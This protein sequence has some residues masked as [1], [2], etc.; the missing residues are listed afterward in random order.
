[1]ALT[2]QQLITPVSESEAFDEAIAILQSLGFNATSW[3]SGS[4]PYTLVRLIA[5]LQASLS[6]TIAQIVEGAYLATASGAFL[7]LLGE[8]HYGRVRVEA[9]ATT[10]VFR[11][12]ASATAPPH[13]ISVGQLQIATTPTQESSTQTYRNT[14]GGTLNPG[15][16]LDLE[17]VAEVAGA[18]G[19]IPSSQALYLWT[20]LV[21]ATATNP[22][23]ATSGTWITEAGIDR[24]SDE[25]YRDRCSSRWSTLSYAAT[26]GAYR[27]WALEASSSVTRVKVRDDNP[28]GPGSI[29]V[30]VAS[31]V[32]SVSEA[33]RQTVEDYINGADG[34]GRRPLNDVLTVSKALVTTI[35]FIGTVTVESAKQSETNSGTI[36]AAVDAYLGELAI[37][38]VVIPPASSGVVPRS[39]LIALLQNM[40]GVLTVNLSTPAFDV[41]LGVSEVVVGSYANLSVVYV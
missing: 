20:P 5:R 6:L 1:M 7:D 36:A 26:E 23:D 28:Y 39:Q 25:R 34:V 31:S 37:G 9:T 35:G 11:L 13:T 16:T 33:V 29:E 27:N 10:G 14:T 30:I 18:A 38:G 19:N 8:S 12:T 32:G 2:V 17:V 22:P 41:G 40:P 4:R 15:G 24:E 3:Q 21:G